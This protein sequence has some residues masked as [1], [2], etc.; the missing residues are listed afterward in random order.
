MSERT[1]RV[2]QSKSITND[3]ARM[4]ERAKELI[5]FGSE[6]VIKDSSLLIDFFRIYTKIFPGE[7]PCESCKKFHGGYFEKF[8]KNGIEI[9][10]RMQ[11]NKFKLKANRI[12]NDV[13]TG[14][15][16][17]HVNMT[18]EK[19]IERLKKYPQTIDEWDEYP[20]NWK[21]LI[22]GEAKELAEMELSELKQLATDKGIDFA[23]NAGVKKMIKLLNEA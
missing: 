20:D 21:E 9:L 15:K 18:D 22:K 4:L 10:E 12:I 19:A 2:L 1:D 5:Q 3:S 14:E 7:N 8:K 16:L 23:K 17:S 6:R 13:K 11:N